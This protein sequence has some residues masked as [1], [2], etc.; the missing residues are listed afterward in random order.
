M[1]Y[2]SIFILTVFFFPIISVFYLHPLCSI[3]L[4]H[5]SHMFTVSTFLTVLHT[6]HPFV[7]FTLLSE[8]CFP[9]VLSWFIFI[10]QSVFSF[11]LPLYLYLCITGFAVVHVYFLICKIVSCFLCSVVQSSV[12]NYMSYPS[13]YPEYI[14]STSSSYFFTKSFSSIRAVHTFVWRLFSSCSLMVYI[15]ST[16]SLRFWFAIISLYYSICC[17]PCR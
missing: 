8:E 16:I 12:L 11:G 1:V 2:I 13:V 15:Y 9:P 4:V 10:P 7:L 6:F 3:L 14:H 5:L 17:T